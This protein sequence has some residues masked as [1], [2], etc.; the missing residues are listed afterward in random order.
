MGKRSFTQDLFR[1]LRDLAD[2]NDRDWFKANKDRYVES[3]QEPALEFI[4][5]FAPYLHKIS[6]HFR[7]D[8]RPVGGSLFR[9]QRDTRF[10]KDKT[11]Y[12][13]HTGIQFRHA[14]AA[15][16]HTPGYYLHLEP[17]NVMAVAGIWRPD[18]P[19][20][21]AIRQAIQ[22]DPGRWRRATRGKSFTAVYSLEG[23]SYVRPPK[24]VDPE[25]PLMD[26]LKLKDF[27]GR[28]RLTQKQATSAGF[29][30]DYAR[31]SRAATP[32]MHFLCDALQIPF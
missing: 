29:L 14:S 17:G 16:A 19:S 27:Y 10:S 22:D 1:F 26:D 30:D 13:T 11:P 28:T 20:L 4:L 5:D 24:D 25:H 7:A 15:D 2:H 21:R 6:P 9:I 32:M 3:V 8:A 18:Q 31:M 12:K 23:E